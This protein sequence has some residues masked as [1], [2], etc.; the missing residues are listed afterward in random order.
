[1]TNGDDGTVRRKSSPTSSEDT[2]LVDLHQPTDPTPKLLDAVTIKLRDAYYGTIYLMHTLEP[3]DEER[4]QLKAEFR[5]AVEQTLPSPHSISRCTSGSWA[6]S[7][8][9]GSACN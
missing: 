3:T 8:R 4:E 7:V 1:M 2:T 9:T 6:F 5:L